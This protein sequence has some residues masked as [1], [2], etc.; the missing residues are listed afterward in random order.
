MRGRITIPVTVLVTCLS[1]T[2][3]LAQIAVVTPPVDLWADPST[4]HPPRR[5]LYPRENVSGSSRQRHR[6]MLSR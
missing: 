1:V 3:A 6:E 4:N 5:L 2:S